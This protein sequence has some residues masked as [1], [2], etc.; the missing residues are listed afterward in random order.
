ML[1]RAA[2]PQTVV[3]NGLIKLIVLS[4]PEH[5]RSHQPLQLLTLNQLRSKEQASRTS[6]V[7]ISTT[8]QAQHLINL[9]LLRT[10]F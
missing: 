2:V 9:R 5:R 1:D 4:R 6:K 7:R 3:F 10:K 8:K